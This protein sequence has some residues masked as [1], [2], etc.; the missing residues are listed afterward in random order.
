[1]LNFK[2]K[3]IFNIYVFKFEK[4]DNSKKFKIILQGNDKWYHSN[5][6]N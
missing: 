3:V 1:M 4:N 5:T 2:S 6:S